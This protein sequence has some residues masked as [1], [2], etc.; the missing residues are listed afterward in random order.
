MQR[1]CVLKPAY[2]RIVHRLS[3]SALHEVFFGHSVDLA[4]EEAKLSKRKSAGGGPLTQLYDGLV[5]IV[6]TFGNPTGA[7][8][9]DARRRRLVTLARRHNL[10]VLSDDV[11]QLLPFPGVTPPPRLVSHDL[12]M[13]AGSGGKC[14]VLS[15]GSYSG[16]SNANANLAGLQNLNLKIHLM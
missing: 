8:L 11:Y 16:L 5:F 10:L 15:N 6:P 3:L 14:H 7:T 1:A 12:Q 4:E 9:P 13:G 2:V